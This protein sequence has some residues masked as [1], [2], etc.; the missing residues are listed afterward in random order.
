M[1]TSPTQRTLALLRK[2]GHQ[3][4]VVEK[5]IPRARKRKDVA[6]C[7]DVIAYGRN[8][9]VLGVQTTT[10]AHHGARKAKALAEPRLVE[11]LM[12]NARF[13]IWSWRK[14]ARSRRWVCRREAVQL[15]DITG[16]EG[17]VE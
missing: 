11:W 15:V 12:A 7:I 4:D 8:L 3:A 1:S 5:W 6:G 10:A 2:E 14:D 16:P 9:G 13:E 17:G